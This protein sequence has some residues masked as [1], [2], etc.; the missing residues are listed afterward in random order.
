MVV[1]NPAE[2]TGESGEVYCTVSKSSIPILWYLFSRDE[3]ILTC[4]ATHERCLP[5]RYGDPL[6]LMMERL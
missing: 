5:A 2:M 6:P 3:T 4:V 1:D